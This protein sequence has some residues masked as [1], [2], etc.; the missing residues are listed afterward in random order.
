MDRPRAVMAYSPPRNN[1]F[2]TPAVSVKEVKFCSSYWICASP[3][4]IEMLGGG[5]AF[6]S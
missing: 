6:S 5:G 4:R 3:E 1:P 2:K